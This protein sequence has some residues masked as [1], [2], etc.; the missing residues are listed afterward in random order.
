[1][2]RLNDIIVLV[3]EVSQDEKFDSSGFRKETENTEREIYASVDSVFASEFYKAKAEGI[4]LESIITVHESEYLGEKLIKYN[5]TM[6][7]VVRTYSKDEY[8]YISVKAS[9]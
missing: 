3:G 6:F 4:K 5:N 1:M 7:E 9:E 2:N 8:T